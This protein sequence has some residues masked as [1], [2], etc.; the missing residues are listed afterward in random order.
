VLV[1]RKWSGKTLADHRADRKAF[2][3]QALAAI[4]IEKPGQDT[5]RLIWRKVAPGDPH[6][7][8]RAHLL[9]QAIAERIAWRAEYDRAMVAA[10]GPPPGTANVSAIPEAA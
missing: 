2:V 3:A 1:S 9:M 7:P 4:G 8:P 5:S 6:V 10:T